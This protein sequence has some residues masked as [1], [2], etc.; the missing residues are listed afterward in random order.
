MSAA[1]P[2]RVCI[3]GASGR[4][5]RMLIEAVRAS[6]DCTLAGALDVAGSS[7]IGQDAGAYA[8]QTTGVAITADLAAGL[9]GAHCLIDF[10]RPEGTMAHLEA[11]VAGGVNL[12]I[13]TTGV[14]V[15]DVIDLAPVRRDITP[16]EPAPTIAARSAPR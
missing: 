8:G 13:G 12:V 7:A 6:G 5:G 1:T 14:V 15:D 9:R 4:M 10:T 16:R 2:Q 11:C 3:A